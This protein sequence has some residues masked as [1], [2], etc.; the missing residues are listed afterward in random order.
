MSGYDLPTVNAILNATSTVLI[1]AG[2]WA[3]RTRRIRLH[4]GMMLTALVTSALFLAS[5]LVYHFV[6]RQGEATRY[7]GELRGGLSRLARVPHRPGSSGGPPGFAHRR[8]SDSR[9]P[10]RTPTPRPNH[11]TNLVVCF[12]H[13]C[14]DI[15]FLKGPVSAGVMSC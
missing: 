7:E 12:R 6:V 11:L 10:C 15:L 8:T 4:Q 3:V 9:T 13:R 1:A 2:Y 5:Y 14:C